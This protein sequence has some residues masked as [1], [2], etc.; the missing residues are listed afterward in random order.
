MKRNE[1]TTVTYDTA[2]DLLAVLEELDRN[3]SEAREA[4]STGMTGNKLKISAALVDNLRCIVDDAEEY[5]ASH[6][7]AIDMHW[8]ARPRKKKARAT[9]PKGK[10]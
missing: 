8:E 5:L 9:P 4:I 3:V 7:D 2:Q 10:S 1:Q 6:Y